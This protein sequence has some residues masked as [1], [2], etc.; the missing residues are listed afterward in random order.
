MSSVMFGY[1]DI[2]RR[3]DVLDVGEDVDN[4]NVA[5]EPLD[6]VD[7]VDESLSVKPARE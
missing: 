2:E 7:W 6:A 4:G 3:G 1:R 5:V